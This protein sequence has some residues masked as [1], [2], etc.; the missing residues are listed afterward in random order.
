MILLLGGTSESSAIATALARAGMKVLVSKATDEPL[1]VGEHANI[2]RRSGR[3]D[4]AQ[5][6]ELVGRRG[7]RAI[8]DA[9]HPYAAAAHAA[10]AG[11]AG[12][13]GIACVRFVRAGG[14]EAGEGV[15]FAAD[16][17]AAA[18]LAFSFGRPVL[19]TSANLAGGREARTLAD[20]PAEDRKSV[21]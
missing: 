7:V 1:A 19:L 16:H 17:T 12:R 6:L 3:L 13:A 10:A 5:M 9:T 4:E 2:E 8:V 15:H 21:V 18:R 11:V 20:V 14:I